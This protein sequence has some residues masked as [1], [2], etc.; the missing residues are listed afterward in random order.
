MLGGGGGR[1]PPE[2]AEPQYY[3]VTCAEGHLVR[4]RRTEGYQAIRCPTC[5][6]GLFILPR[7]PLP[8]PAAPVSRQPARKS[9]P[10]ADSGEVSIE[11]SDAPPQVDADEGDGDVEWLDPEP[12][13]RS[14]PEPAAVLEPPVSAPAPAPAPRKRR[15]EKPTERSPS[16]RAHAKN[17]RPTPARPQPTAR[18][19]PSS[20]VPMIEVPERRGFGEWVRR[21]RHPLLFS[22]VALLVVATVGWRVWRNRYQNLPH[23]AKT[24]ADEGIAALGNGQFDVAKVKLARAA[25]ALRTLGARDAE[26]AK[27][28]QL[29]DEAA[30]LGD[31]SRSQPDEIIAEARRLGD[32]GWPS[33]FKAFY[34]GQSLIIEAPIAALPD[35]KRGTGYTLEFG[36]FAGSG[37]IPTQTGRIDLAGLRIFEN[38]TFKVGDVVAFGARIKDVRLDG[39]EWAIRFQ[40]DSGVWITNYEPLGS[41]GRSSNM[42]ASRSR[43]VSRL[44]A[45]AGVLWL[46]APTQAP[47]AQVVEVEPAGL[48]RRRELAGKSIVIDDRVK[49]FRPD[50]G[51]GY[52]QVVLARTDVPF[53]LPPKLRPSELPKA[54]A[55][56][57][58][59]VLRLDN[60]GLVCDVTAMELF[61]SD[62]ARVNEASSVLRT[63]DAEGRTKWAAWAARR[64]DEFKDPALAERAA[65][66]EREAIQIKT[67]R[68]DPQQ[69]EA[70]LALATE[71]R[72]R[73]VPEPEPSAL[74]FQALRSQFETSKTIAQLDALIK[75]IEELLPGSKAASAG[76]A[77]AWENEAK[78]APRETYLKV[79]AD[80]RSAL[81]RSLLADAIEAKATLE[82]AENPK[83]TIAIVDRAKHVLA[84]RP[85]SLTTLRRKGLDSAVARITSFNRDEVLDLARAVREEYDANRGRAAIRKWLDDRRES[86]LSKDGADERVLLAQDYFELLD[87]RATAIALLRDAVQIDP[88]S[89]PASAA[90][91]QLGLHRVG[92]E[93]VETTSSARRAAGSD[94]E[95]RAAA[96]SD[97][98]PLIG[99][100]AGEVRAQLGQPT[101][102]AR[103][104]SQ[105][106]MI[107]QWI[108]SDTKGK[109]QFINFRF[110]PGQTEAMVVG[111]YSP[112]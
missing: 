9:Q 49:Y 69:P 34:E 29:A 73:G 67:A 39:A 36:V 15:P 19:A 79:P 61:A 68:L 82:I 33:R 24:N 102:I 88:E 99:L 57:I 76:N 59:G 47:A 85:Q 94:S 75:R 53:L 32:D 30:I 31:L 46:V 38:R 51:R 1:K 58:R 91:R 95:P 105:G 56:R 7:S 71:A 35:S 27:I 108:Y 14:A 81:D 52:D 97:D 80:V 96:R 70:A 41:L 20:A 84:D 90:F 21:H 62:L 65:A 66:L 12:S 103:C 92:S 43:G 4:G 3:G 106:Q 100:N 93:W 104:F 8:E 60:G 78:S 28:I 98:D 40:P 83:A 72:E 18:M 111:R 22:A 101:A 74:I 11:W 25:K 23:E 87:D 5:G 77:G 110:R 10:E 37:L 16:P 2:S 44:F 54:R 13:D 63:D 89:K 42:T 109:R 26:S 112:R 6:D 48:S 107:E 50:P 86:K 64:S 45:L 55:A 17:P